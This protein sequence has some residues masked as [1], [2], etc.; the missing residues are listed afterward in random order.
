MKAYL[1]WISETPNSSNLFSTITLDKL[2]NIGWNTGD[3]IIPFNIHL[4]AKIKQ[5]KKTGKMEQN[6]MNLACTSSK[7]SWM[8][9]QQPKAIKWMKKSTKLWT[10]RRTLQD[11]VWLVFSYSSKKHEQ[12]RIWVGAP[13]K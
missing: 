4:V 8:S 11:L 1:V 5:K 2:V 3:P 12:N 13:D 7:Q 9:V 10:I 6:N